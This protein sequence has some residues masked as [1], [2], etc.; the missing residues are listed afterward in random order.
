VDSDHRLLN[1]VVPQLEEVGKLR[2]VSMSPNDAPSMI[3]TKRV[4]E[5]FQEY[6][7]SSSVMIVLEGH[8]TLGVDA[9]HFST[10]SFRSSGRHQA[11]PARPRLR[12][13]S[14]TASGAQSVDGK[15]AYVQVYIAAIK[16]KPSPTSRWRQFAP[17]PTKPLLRRR[18][19]YVTGPAATTA[20]QNAIGDKSM[21][22]IELVTF[23]VITVMLLLVLQIDHH[24]LIVLAMVVLE[25]NWRA[26]PGG[27]SGLPQR[28]RSDYLAPTWW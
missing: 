26:G 23:A 25:L 13:D 2:A 21:Q 1:T 12:G 14:F 27:I 20:D 11:R 19:A 8:D 22:V 5:V 28:V 15:A 6:N 17:S 24:P 3:A 9:H 7:T 18:K 4:G 16:G 10:R